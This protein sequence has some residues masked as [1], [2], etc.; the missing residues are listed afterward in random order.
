MGYLTM[1]KNVQCL[2]A[3]HACAHVVL[4]GYEACMCAFLFKCV[5]HPR[6]ASECMHAFLHAYCM[7][8]TVRSRMS[9]TLCFKHMAA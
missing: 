5:V 4:C 6:A 8:V 9:V 3:L 2:A 7:C 1:G